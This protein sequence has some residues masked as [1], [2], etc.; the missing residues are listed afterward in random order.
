MREPGTVSLYQ[1]D[2][3]GESRAPQMLRHPVLRSGLVPCGCR[4][5]LDPQQSF[6]VS[7]LRE[8]NHP[9]PWDVTARPLLSVCSRAGINAFAKRQ[10]KTKEE[11]H[12]ILSSLITKR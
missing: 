6:P 3:Y 11:E 10:Q 9:C 2:V 12:G 1:V 4:T 5:M 8:L 7:V